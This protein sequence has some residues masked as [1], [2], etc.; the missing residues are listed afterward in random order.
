MAFR[1]GFRRGGQGLIRFNIVTEV[2]RAGCI[3]L[4]SI[5]CPNFAN[6]G[7]F[8]FINNLCFLFQDLGLIEQLDLF[9][10]EEFLGSRPVFS[11][12]GQLSPCV[13]SRARQPASGQAVS[14][15][16]N[17]VVGNLCFLFQDLGLIEQLKLFICKPFI[18]SRSASGRRQLSPC[19]RSRARQL[20]PG[21]TVS[22]SANYV[23][24]NLCFLFQDLGLIEQLDLFLVEEFQG[25]RSGFSAAR[26]LSPCVRSRARQPAPGQA[27]SRSANYVTSN[28]GFL[29]QDLGLIEQVK[30]F[31]GKPFI[32][33]RPVFS[34]RR[35]PQLLRPFPCPPARSRPG[36][37]PVRQ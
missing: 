35:P 30:L 7:G 24:G 2:Q 1:Q 28:L 20:A 31:I 6:R 32:N 37:H 19:V 17:Y 14:R 3:S 26:Q 18:N 9:L 10:V 5:C 16:A 11:A 8:L 23:I 33:S 15:S 13:R 29:F 25:S 12:A 22:R 34:C 4:P 21:Q 36:R 27:V